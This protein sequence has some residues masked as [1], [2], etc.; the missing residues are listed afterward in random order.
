MTNQ[1]NARRNINVTTVCHA[2]H[3][4]P[5]VLDDET[6]SAFMQLPDTARI[7][8]SCPVCGEPFTLKHKDI[9]TAQKEGNKVKQGKK[10][11]KPIAD[12]P[13]ARER[14]NHEYKR[15]A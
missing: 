4:V 3:D 9:H 15:P 13:E 2:G 8:I 12:T 11:L 6:E 10:G 7:Q 1:K 5:L 14:W